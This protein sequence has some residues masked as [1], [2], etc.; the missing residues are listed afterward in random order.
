MASIPT[1]SPI[2]HDL[3]Y[4]RFDDPTKERVEQGR[5]VR[6]NFRLLGDLKFGPYLPYSWGFTIYRAVPPGPE[7]DARF[8]EGVRRLT[9]WMRWL[10]RNRRYTDEDV[11]MWQAHPDLMPQPAD[12][13]AWDDVADRLWNEVVEDYPN[14]DQ[15]DTAELGEE[16][17]SP[18]GE[19]FLAWHAAHER[20]KFGDR[21]IAPNSRYDFCLVID[22]T[23]LRSLEGLLP[24]EPP[25]LKALELGPKPPQFQSW[26]EECR[27]G[28]AAFEAL[29]EP[30]M[31]DTS[32][33]YG[34]MLLPSEQER[35]KSFCREA[36]VWILDRDTMRRYRDGEDFGEFPPWAR[37]QLVH[38]YAV[39]FRRA[40]ECET[41]SWER[42]VE[43]D[44]WQWDKVR[45]WVSGMR[46][47]I[48]NEIRRRHRAERAAEAA[49]AINA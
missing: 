19:A 27:Y 28:R 21:F 37:I 26:E 17:L 31:V 14:A 7:Q 4:P 12:H 33:Q 18:A 13:D 2:G 1:F 8:A 48:A 9:E 47:T 16:D 15:V 41:T 36:W 23:A 46:A 42:H 39:W 38:I 35:A 30:K 10:A 40:N 3:V 45:W 32:P 25:A 11:R 49:A 22:E 29:L 6:A 44:K 43:E 5:V 20:P 34:P 24:A